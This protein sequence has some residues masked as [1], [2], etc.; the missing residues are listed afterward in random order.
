M[1]RLDHLGAALSWGLALA[2]IAAL[3]AS[4]GRVASKV[5]GI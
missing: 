4:V 1:T 5:M 2:G 3:V